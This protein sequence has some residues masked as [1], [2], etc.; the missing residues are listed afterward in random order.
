MTLNEI[1]A[2][3]ITAKA[4]LQKLQDMIDMSYHSDDVLAELGNYVETAVESM[5]DIKG[6]ITHLSKSHDNDLNELE[7]G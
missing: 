5:Q 6:V 1:R 7:V 2:Q 4:E 3:Y